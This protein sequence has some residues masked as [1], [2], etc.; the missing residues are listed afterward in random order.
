MLIYSLLGVGIMAAEL[1][2]LLPW[3]S[4]V[5]ADV[6]WVLSMGGYLYYAHRDLFREIEMEQESGA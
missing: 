2:G 3:W 5:V 4:V 6:A 1:S